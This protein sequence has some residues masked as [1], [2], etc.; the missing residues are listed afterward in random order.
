MGTTTSR[1][2]ITS[3]ALGSILLV[4]LA[5]FT[6]LNAFSLKFLSPATT[7]QTVVFVG[8]SALAFL[9]FVAVLF[10]LVRNV[11]KLYADQQ[12]RV[13]G[14][15]L[16]TRMMWGAILVSL[17]PL[18]FMFLFSYWLMNRAV[19]RWFSEPVT[20]MR[21][22]SN[23]IAL[24]LSQYTSANARTEAESIAASLAVVDSIADAA[25]EVQ[26][27][28]SR[29]G[30][31]RVLHQHEI[32]LQNGFAIVYRE[33]Q[34]VAALH[35]PQPG[36]APVQVKPW[37]PPQ[38]AADEDGNAVSESVSGR[39]PGDDLVVDGPTDAAILAA[40]Q[41]NDLPI[42]SEGGT[43]YALGTTAMKQGGMVVVGL[44]MPFGMSAT[45]AR[46]QKAAD[47]VW[48]MHSSQRQIRSLYLT[49]LMMMTTL[50]L[51]ASSWLALH[52]SKQ[53]TKPIEALADAME[54]IA[55]GDYARRVEASSTEE[56]GEL[57]RSFNHMAADLEGSRRAAETSNIQL[58]AANATLE[59]RRN[60]LE[61]MLEA[62]PNGVATLDS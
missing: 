59:A 33:G 21:D 57:V 55:A 42:F 52:L 58:T 12:S 40:A 37:L 26:D 49:L 28:Q 4:L 62:I 46:L 32:N 10:M 2:K 15:R 51:F 29:E 39:Q 56:L 54:A 24:Q 14:N 61:T 13:L 38:S 43:D 8:L 53:V 45:M 9:V 31:D 1:R 11:L 20:E 19:D 36:G 41:R 23:N 3:I 60:E 16:R 44:P 48:I 25:N 5:A 22:D 30:V 17:I 18:V 34:A 50:A 27:A 7:G 6:A 35:M 47:E